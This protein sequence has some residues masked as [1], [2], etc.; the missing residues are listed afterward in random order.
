M[1]PHGTSREAFAALAYD[2]NMRKKKRIKN[3]VMKCREWLM[4]RK[5]Y[6]HVNLVSELK[7]YHLIMILSRLTF[8][9]SLDRTLRLVVLS[10]N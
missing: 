8:F 4:K 7:I 10:K 1:T 5:I 6:T 2:K 9:K 3:V